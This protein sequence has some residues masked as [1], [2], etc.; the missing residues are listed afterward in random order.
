[1]AEGGR[2]VRVFVSSPG[3]TRF[4]RSRLDRVTQRLNG[5]FQGVA[6][7]TTIRWETEFYRAHDTFQAQIPESAQCDIVVAIFRGR[8]GTELPPDF[9]RMPD[10]SP[11]PSGTAYEVL[12]AIEAAKGRGLPD[13]YVFRFSDSP[14]IQL[15]NPDRAQLEAQWQNLKAFFENWFQTPEG[16]F[17]AA[18]QTFA[19][20]DDFEVQIESLLRKWLEEKVLHGRSVA[21]PV[22]VKGSPFRGLAAFGAK[23]APVFFGRSRD[24]AKAT[25]RLKDAAE[26]GCAFLLVDGPSGS[27]KSSLVRAGLLPRLTAAGVVPHVDV[28]RVAVMRPGELGG[29]PFTALARELFVRAEDLPD[30]EQGRPAALPELAAS[31]FSRPP[32]LAALLAHADD[33]ALKPLTGTLTAIEHAARKKDGY[34]RDVNAALLL[35]VDQLDELFDAQIADDVRA[36]FAQLLGRLARSAR[37]WVIATLRADLFERFLRQQELKQLKDDGGGYDLSAPGAAELAEIVR[38]PATAADLIYETD[39]ATGERLDERLLRDA[40]RTDLLPLLQFALD[41][42]FEAR[43]TV[44]GEARLT[45]AAY[46]AL[47]GLAGAVDKQA[48]AALQAL[49]ETEQAQ[50][51]RLL[52]ELAAPAPGAAGY[53]IRA[54]PVSAAA[55]DEPSKKLVRA[56]VDARILLSTGEGNQATVRLAHARVLDSWQRAKAIVAENAE[57]YRIRA[58][59]DEQRRRWEASGRKAELLIP[60]GLP[61]AEAETIISSYGAE[62][63]VDTRDFVATSGRRARRRQR[64]TAAAAAVFAALA[65]GAT[66]LGLLAYQA[67]QRA[68]RNFAQAEASRKEAQ[69]SLWIANSRSELRDGR[70]TPAVALAAKAFVE[71]PNEASRSALASALF[72]VSPHLQATFD[73]GAGGDE[74]LA[75]T[76]HDA[77]V[78]A[79]REGDGQ[80]RT[81]ATATAAPTAGTMNWAIPRLTRSQDGNPAKIRALRGVGARHLMA[82]LDNGAVALI[83]RDAAAAYVRPPLQRTTL[84]GAGDAAAIGRTGSLI[85]FASVDRDVTLIECPMAAGRPSLDDCRER[86][87]A[88]VRGKAVAVSPDE[89]RIAVGDYAGAVAIYD[90]SGARLGEP[91]KV[92]GSLLSLGWAHARNWLAAGNVDGEIVVLDLDAPAQPAVA[93]ASLPGAPI[94]T[95]VWSPVALQLA[96]ACSQWTV[97]L[98]PGAD[99]AGAAG[100]ASFAPIRRFERHGSP[101]TRL[102]WSPGG[103]RIASAAGDATIRVWSVAQNTDAGFMLYT[104]APTQI[105]QVATSHDGRWVAGGATDGSIRIWDAA[106]TALLRT[107]RSSFATEVA[108]LAWSRVGM[109]AAAHDGRGITL[110]PADATA[111]VREIDIDTD[112]DTHIAFIEDDKT[113]ALPQRSDK[114]IVLI[115]AAKTETRRY[116]DPIGSIQAPWGLAAHPAGKTLFASYTDSDDDIYAWDLA[117]GKG[118]K[119]DYALPQP[120]NSSASGSLAVTRDGRWLAVSGGDNYVRLYDVARKT[121]R[122]ALQ[123][124][125]NE[126]RVVAFSPDGTRLA[127]VGGDNRLYIWT[128]HEGRAERFAV[129]NTLL[130]RSAVEDGDRRRDGA[131]WLDWVTNDRIALATSGSAITIIGLDPAAW[132][133]RVDG[134]AIA[135]PTPLN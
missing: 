92:G 24:I 26:K 86:S 70:V 107:I 73:V 45:F 55:H 7:L 133:R 59:V 40:D 110:V 89:T 105:T 30:A 127:A 31:D 48:E 120:R 88:N 126:S 39:S 128:L 41:Q 78:F 84:H 20:T 93:K 132:R 69:A 121:T 38:G 5:E 44:H 65:V 123:M 114:R 13:V 134:L 113:I 56:L 22:D 101:V 115:D 97:C 3:D 111:P 18:F 1:M 87:L 75:W 37:V 64:L 68:Q 100:N 51:P 135:T 109:L 11:Y 58:E 99:A 104:E 34:D 62:L 8:L 119:L 4:E 77:L 74:A 27:G 98:W 53:D 125:G 10:G 42:L 25:D 36:R 15:D 131:L 79:S 54:V 129:M 35:V 6:R 47:G 46:H 76:G 17:K 12:S 23:H 43:A 94:T 50:L 117:T 96:F 91:I 66:V 106:S 122:L 14:S 108:S 2:Q 60:G 80:L 81:L 83:E 32:E 49:G 103:E 90:R 9:P 118:A 85:A 95:L 72:E 124:D 33:T 130:A 116:L 63:S 52:R 67:E 61:L 71:L 19:S 16:R 82:V 28:W 102:A 57:F 112:S 29:D 21:W